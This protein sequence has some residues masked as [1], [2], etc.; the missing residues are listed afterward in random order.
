MYITKENSSILI[1]SGHFPLLLRM[2]YPVKTSLL[3]YYKYVLNH[4]T[5][6]ISVVRYLPSTTIVLIVIIIATGFNPKDPVYK[7]VVGK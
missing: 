3:S 2:D 6:W 7:R 5:D 4:R 1:K